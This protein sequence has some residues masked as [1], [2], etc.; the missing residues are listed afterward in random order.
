MAKATKHALI[1]SISSPVQEPEERKNVSARTVCVAWC[2][3]AWSRTH[4][5]KDSRSLSFFC[6]LGLAEAA[7]LSWASKAAFTVATPS[8]LA[9]A[10]AAHSRAYL[11]ALLNLSGPFPFKWPAAVGI[12]SS[13][14]WGWVGICVRPSC[15]WNRICHLRWKRR[16]W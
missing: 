8:A 5:K 4:I 9:R 6:W 11:V 12:F 10:S 13:R 15:L 16:W 2:W 1:L 3:T 14:A 7:N